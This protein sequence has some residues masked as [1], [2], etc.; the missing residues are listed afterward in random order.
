MCFTS[1]EM[2]SSEKQLILLSAQKCKFLFVS[3]AEVFFS[4]HS[5]WM[6]QKAPRIFHFSSFSC[7]RECSSKWLFKL[8]KNRSKEWKF[9]VSL[10]IIELVVRLKGC[11]LSRIFLNFQCPPL[12]SS[13]ITF[14]KSQQSNF[15]HWKRFNK[16]SY[17][18]TMLDPYQQ[19]VYNS[20]KHGSGERNPQL[21]YFSMRKRKRPHKSWAFKSFF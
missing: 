21:L 8:F 12:D 16:R 13:E 19:H 5:R 9:A 4:L 10:L 20:M 15:A 7:T 3:L 1:I 14:V 6:P 11:K 18:H 2:C 17:L